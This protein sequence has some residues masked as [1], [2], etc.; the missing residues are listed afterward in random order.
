MGGVVK[1][2]EVN[3]VDP[4]KLV[5][6]KDNPRLVFR[7]EDMLALQESIKDQGILVPLTVYAEGEKYRLLDGERR[8]R[9]AIKLG[10]P[11]VPVIIQAKP[12]PLTNI[13]MMFA[14]HH[15]R[16]D[17]D[18]LPTALKLEE[19]DKM[20][21][22]M[23]GKEATEKELAGLASM[24]VGEVRRLKK[25]LALPSEY[26]K[27]LLDELE[28]PRAEQLLTVDHVLEAS[29]AT[30]ALR[31]AQVLLPNEEEK[32][33]RAIVEKFRNHVIKN[34][35]APRKLTKLARAV[36]RKQVSIAIARKAV[37]NVRDRE[38]YTIDDAYRDTVEQADFEHNLT[39]L[40]D[41]V[42][43]LINEHRKRGFEL[44]T[45][46]RKA[47]EQLGDLIGRFLRKK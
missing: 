3:L 46:T 27:E 36:A 19:L 41:R 37:F 17:W 9:S 15:A 10:M 11:R 13:M 23:H 18:P 42:Q 34:T 43:R 5:R 4:H 8:W 21:K 38:K 29:T 30:G 1:E 26:R 25:L 2:A 44:S 45:A 35:V 39:L 31:K 20:F 12:E 32:V 47:L 33:R 28:K 6:N 14:I 24:S 40:T 22:R 16:K 7:E